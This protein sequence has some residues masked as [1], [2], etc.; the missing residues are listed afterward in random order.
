[1][2]VAKVIHS[3][4]SIMHLFFCLFVPFFFFFCL[5]FPL[6]SLVSSCPA[7][8]PFHH[9]PVS[10]LSIHICY[11][12][13]TPWCEGWLAINQYFTF[14]WSFLIHPRNP[15]LRSHLACLSDTRF[16]LHPSFSP[17]LWLFSVQ[18]APFV[19]LSLV[20][21]SLTIIPP[22]LFPPNS[23]IS[24]LHPSRSGGLTVPCH[25]CSGSSQR[26]QLLIIY[27]SDRLKCYLKMGVWQSGQMRPNWLAD[28]KEVSLLA[29]YCL[30]ANNQHRTYF[31]FP[32]KV[33]VRLFELWPQGSRTRSACCTPRFTAS[34]RKPEGSVLCSFSHLVGIYCNPTFFSPCFIK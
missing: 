23:H 22:C 28:L 16:L 18:S 34:Q 30:E 2:L 27:W 5:I 31:A 4:T 6:T 20:V 21:F 8:T 26:I 1:M 25:P 19:F 11:E 13:K 29:V 15:S 17:T 33:T 32:L 10:R 14:A 7:P 24:Q 9:P 3:S 12:L